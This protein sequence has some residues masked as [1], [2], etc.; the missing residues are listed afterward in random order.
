[1]MA[2]WSDP[3]ISNTAL[4]G[5]ILLVTLVVIALRFFWIAAM[6]RVARDTISG[7]RRK[8]TPERWRSAAV[9]T[10]GGPKG[11]ITLSLMF[12]IPYYIAGGAPFP[13][14]D[15]LIFIASGVIIVTLLLANFLLPLLAPNRGK[16]PSAEIIPVTIDVLRA[17][18]EELT[19]RITPENR[20][21]I[22]MVIDQYTKRIGR[23]QQRIGDT[24]SPGI[25]AIADRSAALGK[26]IRARPACRHQSTSGG[27]YGH[28]RAERRNLRAHA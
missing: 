9:M 3:Y 14:R 25:R 2:S 27:G 11:T 21:A 4:I 6:L 18:V 12:T 15:E 10:F 24:G 13:M 26:G 23:L 17:T 1:M 22:L 5:I 20:R 28:A 7:Q 8:M 16:D 19:G